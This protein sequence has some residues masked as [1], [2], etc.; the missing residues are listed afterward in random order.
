MGWAF[1]RRAPQDLLGI[2]LPLCV[3]S[4]NPLR[5]AQSRTREPYSRI[6]RRPPTPAFPTISSPDDAQRV[7][8][9]A[10]SKPREP[11]QQAG[12]PVCFLVLGAAVPPSL[13]SAGG[14]CLC[15]V[16]LRQLGSS[17]SGP[18]RVWSDAG[19]APWGR[20]PDHRPSWWY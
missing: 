4:Q 5:H 19:S 20:R 8:S 2:M 16:P 13:P 14:Q 18:H 17:T 7:A 3:W 6:T 1:P 9:P 15:A 12:F 10:T 11:A